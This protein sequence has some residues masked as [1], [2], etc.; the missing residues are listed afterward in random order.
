MTKTTKTTKI[1][2][3][4]PC[5]AGATLYTVT[6]VGS[7]DMD[8]SVPYG[9]LRRLARD[10]YRVEVAANGDTAAHVLPPTAR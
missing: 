2:I 8:A 1:A 4:T 10:G 3:A 7:R 5:G 6:Y 9:Y